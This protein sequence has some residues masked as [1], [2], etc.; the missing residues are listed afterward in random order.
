MNT[1][2]GRQNTKIYPG[3]AVPIY[4]PQMAENAEGKTRMTEEVKSK[5]TKL[6]DGLWIF[7]KAVLAWGTYVGVQVLM[8][9][10]LAA[11]VSNGLFTVGYALSVSVMISAMIHMIVIISSI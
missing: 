9:S 1:D 5:K 7:A 10:A 11:G 2:A 4:K 3:T 8:V 6:Q